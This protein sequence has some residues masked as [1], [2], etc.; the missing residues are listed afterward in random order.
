MLAT[1]PVEELAYGDARNHAAQCRDCDRVTRVVAERERNM[2]LA[3]GE[4]Y[5][6]SATDP[7]TAQALMISRRRRVAL[8]YRIGLGILTAA[9]L[10]FYV[11]ARR[12]TPA[13]SRYALETFHLQCLSPQQAVEVL[14]PV[15]SPNV[16]V[17]IPPGSLG[18][19]RVTA[20]AEEMQRIRSVL[21]RYDSPAASECGVQLTVPKVTNVP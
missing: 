16:S 21:D 8:Y 13:S 20:S 19:I 15:R 12:L 9:T 18:I 1:V 7:I 4:L 6:S 17:L 10:L 5:P 2:R 11:G 3:Y 14:R